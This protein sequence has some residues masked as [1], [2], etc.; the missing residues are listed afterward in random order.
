MPPN[1][2]ALPEDPQ[3]APDIGDEA[4]PQFA[5]TPETEAPVEVDDAHIETLSVKLKL[6][7]E[8]EE[9]IVKYLRENLPKMRPAPEEE[10]QIRAY[11]ESYDMKMYKRGFPYESAPSMPSSDLHDAVNTW[12]D[13]SETAFLQQKVTF[14]IDRENSP[15]TEE[16][17][18]RI[19]KTMHRKFFLD[20]GFSKDLRMILFESAVL[21]TSFVTVRENYDLKPTRE[22]L[23]IKTPQD[24]EKD[25]LSLTK[26][27]QEDAKKAIAN[28][29]NF[30]TE[31][32]MIQIV[33]IGPVATR[34]DQTQLWYPR[35][36]KDPKKWQIVSE[37]EFYTKSALIE[38]G[39]RGEIDLKKVQQSVA[40]RRS[41][42]A[43]KM[44]MEEGRGK[45]GTLEAIKKDDLD[46]DWT[47]SGEMER[48]KEMGDAYDDEFA[49]Y[50]V[51]MLYNTP[52]EHDKSGRLRSW[53][54]VIFCPAGECLLDS[55]FCPD[56]FPVKLVQYRP[57]S[58]S[59]LGVGIGKERFN[60]NLLDSDLKSY[61]LAS[62]EQELGNPLLIRKQSS[63]WSTDFRAYPGAVG[64]TENPQQ[65]LHYIQ[66]PP[67]S[68]HAIEGMKMVTENT[69]GSNQGAGY[70]SGDR[71]QILQQQ[72]DLKIKARLHSVATD[73]DQVFNA[74]WKIY[75][76]MS[77]LNSKEK[78]YVDWIVPTAPIDSKLYILESEMIPELTWSSVV[79]TTSLSPDA[80]L[81]KAMMEKEILHDKVPA[82]VNNPRLTI[83]WSSYIADYMG[84]TEAQKKQLLPTEEDF[85]AFQAQI[86]DQGGE[87]PNAGKPPGAPSQPG[88]PQSPAINQ[89]PSTAFRG[90]PGK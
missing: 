10:E 73:L 54:E 13:T 36:V 41:K 44:S 29:E 20:S 82:S 6:D 35:N 76:R 48:I 26:K 57:T 68:S 67:K 3:I 27:E 5:E 24:L 56:G 61:F 53:I 34:V 64:F 75:C 1:D 79:S 46:S 80:R 14:A 30:T 90:G 16:Q 87:R 74:A 62:L 31:K 52:S 19:E 7:K 85:A 38:L 4:D 84:Y 2:V 86:G 83:A 49:I 45:S 12:L 66:M 51:T 17:C 32:E 72:R 21:S 69:A 81:Q 28:G 9:N 23:I 39:E 77:K 78:S 55:A 8:D 37:R 18:R 33:N 50:K 89:S 88:M 11:L 40:N 65:D 25:F 43:N 59:A 60:H 15:Y 71:E 63:L 42:Y 22:K 58:Y 47:G 70:A